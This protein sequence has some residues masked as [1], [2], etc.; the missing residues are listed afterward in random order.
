MISKVERNGSKRMRYF[1]IFRTFIIL[2]LFISMCFCKNKAF[3]RTLTFDGKTVEYKEAS[4]KFTLDGKTVKGATG[5]IIDGTSLAPCNQVFIK[6]DM[7]ITY[8]YSKAKGKLYLYHGKDVIKFTLGANYAYVNDVKKTLGTPARIIKDGST[9][10]S[11]VYVPSRFVATTFGFDYLWTKE[12]GIVSM[13]TKPVKLTVGKKTVNYEG[14]KVNVTCNS[15]ALTTSSYFGLSLNV[16]DEDILVPAKLTFA[17]K[18]VGCDYINDS[19]AKTVTLSRF[20]NTLVMN[21]NSTKA[22]LN[23]EEIE[24]SA[25]PSIIKFAS[26]GKNVLYVPLRSV[27]EALDLGLSYV[28]GEKSADITVPYAISI[29]GEYS[30]PEVKGRVSFDGN[31][32]KVEPYYSVI[33]NNTA[34]L[35]AKKIFSATLG[36]TYQYD[37]TSKTILFT[38]NDNVV[39]MTV[40]SNIAFVNGEQVTIENPPRLVR[41]DGTTSDMVMVPGRFTANALGFDYEWNADLLMSVITTHVEKDDEDDDPYEDDTDDSEVPGEVID[42]EPENIKDIFVSDYKT[43]FTWTYNPA[44]LPAGADINSGNYIKGVSGYTNGY[45]YTIEFDC[46]GKCEYELQD[47]YATNLRV[48]IKGAKSL[49]NSE[50]FRNEDPNAV[51]KG[52]FNMGALENEAT[53]VV[54]KTENAE[55]SFSEEGNKIRVIITDYS[56]QPEGINVK[57]PLAEG[58]DISRISDEDDYFNNR[59]VF[60][61]PGDQRAFLDANPIVSTNSSITSITKELNAQGDTVIIMKCKKLQTYRMSFT[62]DALC[63]K[64]G[65]PKDIYRYI[66][67]MDAGHGGKDPGAQYYGKNEK[68]LNLAVAYEK[69]DRFFVKSDIKAYYTR[70]DDTFMELKDRAAFAGKVGADMFV[71]VHMNALPSNKAIYGTSVYYSSSNKTK[72]NSVMTSSK[73]AGVFQYDLTTELGMNDRS[74]KD[75]AFYVCKNNVVPAVLIELGFMTN[76]SEFDKLASDDFQ[77]AA[78]QNIFGSIE[79][80]FN[81]YGTGR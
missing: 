37:E 73:M 54:S 2:G 70:K 23:G 63:L 43:G 57:I 30:F 38:G 74:K 26:T 28:D 5:F 6:T 50:N 78:A 7:G 48:V 49:L 59:F 19:K 21:Y 71:S 51:L 14:T 13:K 32:V 39:I 56:Y 47:V 40:D 10:K 80:I 17:G 46:T 60:I 9:G 79:Y 53:F 69:I 62:K 8:K 72:M 24:L 4:V 52:F 68:D 75:S 33:Q 65:N 15:A 76:K 36:C 67:V 34:L 18:N 77:L 64:T 45:S 44:L 55:L 31:E 35:R 29:N 27:C 42:Y 16:N 1:K 61:I 22:I 41:Y 81:T 25:A 66:V 3:A 11:L 58:T 20:G 12:T